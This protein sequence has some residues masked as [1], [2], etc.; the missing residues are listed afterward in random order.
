MHVIVFHKDN[1]SP[2]PF[3]SCQMNDRLNK[4]LSLIVLW[5]GLTGDNNLHRVFRVIDDSLQPVRVLE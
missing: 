2:E 5:M 3:L 4:L 1:A